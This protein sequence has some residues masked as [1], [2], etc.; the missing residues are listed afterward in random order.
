MA[1]TRLAG[2]LLALALALLFARSSDRLRSLET[3]IFAHYLPW[4]PSLPAAWYAA[5]PAELDTSS[6]ARPE[7]MAFDEAGDYGQAA[8]AMKMCEDAV[9]Y[10][11]GAIV[12][13]D[14]NRRQWK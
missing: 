2:V 3:L 14:C 9:P 7:V 6:C 10:N 13:C 1:N 11:G 5:V 4:A 12:S 8:S